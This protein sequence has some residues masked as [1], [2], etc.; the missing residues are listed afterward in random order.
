MVKEGKKIQGKC[1]EKKEGKLGNI[2]S[3]SHSRIIYLDCT[4]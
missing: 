4:K 2:Y 1:V 3:I